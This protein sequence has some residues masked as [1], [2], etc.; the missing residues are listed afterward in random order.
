M[1]HRL[2]KLMKDDKNELVIMIHD[3]ESNAQSFINLAN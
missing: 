1:D 2:R 3:V